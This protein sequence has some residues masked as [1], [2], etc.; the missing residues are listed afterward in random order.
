MNGLCFADIDFGHVRDSSYADH[1]YDETGAP[2]YTITQYA[3]T[4]TSADGD[5]YF[6]VET[7]YQEFHPASCLTGTTNSGSTPGIPLAEF[8]V[9][10]SSGGTFGSRYYY[11]QYHRPIVMTS[12]DYT[13]NE[14]IWIQVRYE[15]VGQTHKDYTVKVHSKQSGVQVLKSGAANQLFTDGASPSEFTNTTYTGMHTDCSRY[16]GTSS[17]ATTTESTDQRM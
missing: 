16:D 6:T 1:W 17:T 12:S 13:A 4:P 3:F 9:G 15:W 7:Y 11:D 8:G 2:E 14:E 10:T 5:L